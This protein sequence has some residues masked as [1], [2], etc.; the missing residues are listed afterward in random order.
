MT[1]LLWARDGEVRRQGEKVVLL[2]WAPSVKLCR[3]N[4]YGWLRVD[5]HI[6]E[7]VEVEGEEGLSR[8]RG[9]E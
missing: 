4:E 1:F 2:L 8:I 7:M 6:E 5:I 3:R 9:V